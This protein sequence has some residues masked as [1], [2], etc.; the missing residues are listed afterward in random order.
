MSGFWF[1]KISLFFRRFHDEFMLRREWER[2]YLVFGGHIFFQTLRTAVQLDLF[3]L[4]DKS[5]PLTRSE[6]ASKLG[7]EEQPARIV[8]LGCASVGLLRKRGNAYSN[9]E[10]ARRLL[11]KDSP[12]RILAYIELQHHAMYKAMPWMYEAVREYRNVGLKEFK[13]DEPSLYQRLVHYPELEQIFQDAMQELSVHANADLA[14][15]VDFSDVKHVVDVGGG[16]GTNI[17]ELARQWPHL[18]ATVFDSPSVCEIAK[19]NI[20]ASGFKDRLGTS[21]GECFT[22]PFPEEADCLLF[23]HFFTI[24]SEEKNRELLKKAHDSLP[25]GGKV[26]IFNMMQNDD[27]TGPLSAAIG[28]PYFL[29]LATGAGMLY[30]WNEYETWTKKAGF[31]DVQRYTLPRDHGAIMAA[32][33]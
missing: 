28:S 8:L 12:E 4:L 15:F 22:T 2:L 17:I 33:P 18:R 5:G 16:D 7:I 20:E 19:K 21:P 10:L 25:S 11:V 9:S 30:T 13:G 31:S 3:S 14:K 32:K 29:T 26:T 1:R 6:I 23:C 27:E 24:W